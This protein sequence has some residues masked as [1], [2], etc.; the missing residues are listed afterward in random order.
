MAGLLNINSSSG[1]VIENNLLFDMRHG[2]GL[3]GIQTDAR[4]WI[5]VND[6]FSASNQTLRHQTLQLVRAV[7]AHTPRLMSALTNYELF[8]KVEVVWQWVNKESVKVEF[9]Y[10][11]VLDQAQLIYAAPW[12]FISE[13]GILKEILTFSYRE[14]SWKY[15]GPEPDNGDF[16]SEASSEGFF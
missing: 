1:V 4:G 9:D 3:G 8:P 7:D 12:D 16:I 5:T 11:I 2:L 15:L 10:R 13:D 6:A 14:I